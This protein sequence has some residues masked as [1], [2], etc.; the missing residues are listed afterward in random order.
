MFKS[1]LLFIAILGF[2]LVPYFSSAAEFNVGDSKIVIDK[3]KGN[4]A[5]SENGRNIA[6][7]ILKS[8]LK[9][10]TFLSLAANSEVWLKIVKKVSGESS[11][12]R[13]TSTECG[14][15]CSYDSN[16]GIVTTVPL[17]NGSECKK[18]ISF[19]DRAR[20]LAGIQKQDIAYVETSSLVLFTKASS[21]SPSLPLPEEVEMT[22]AVS[23]PTIVKLGVKEIGTYNSLRPASGNVNTNIPSP[24][25]YYSTN[26]ATYVPGS[27]TLTAGR[28]GGA[29]PATTSGTSL[30][31]Q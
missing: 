24:K 8:E 2:I 23:T 21:D 3:V 29:G 12:L 16:T 31:T 30:S 4:V 15:K 19:L 28:R 11:F 9:T 13:I 27:T 18:S 7:G 1:A 6:G 14:T 25:S 10:G 22:P 17:N 26:E 5:L 20:E